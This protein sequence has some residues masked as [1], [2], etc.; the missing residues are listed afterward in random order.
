MKG[1]KGIVIYCL[2]NILI[3]IKDNSYPQQLSFRLSAFLND[4]FPSLNAIPAINSEPIASMLP[5]SMTE[6]D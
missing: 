5:I 3:L 2:I 1:F 4:S 6:V